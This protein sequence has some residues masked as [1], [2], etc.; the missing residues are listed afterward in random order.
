MTVSDGWVKRRRML[1]NMT[2]AVKHIIFLKSGIDNRAFM[3]FAVPLKCSS[4]KK[5]KSKIK[6]KI[7]IKKVDWMLVIKGNTYVLR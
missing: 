7:K 1:T 3:T 5:S 6:S 4:I 2:K